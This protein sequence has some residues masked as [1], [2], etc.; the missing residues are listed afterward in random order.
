MLFSRISILEIYKYLF[1]LLGCIISIYCTSVNTT[2]VEKN[3]IKYIE[4]LYDKNNT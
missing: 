1:G 3:L 2:S 4:R